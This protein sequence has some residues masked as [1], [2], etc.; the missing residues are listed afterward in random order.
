MSGILSSLTRWL[1]Q[2]QT[3]S[4]KT[5]QRLDE[6]HLFLLSEEWGKIFLEVVALCLIGHS[7]ITRPWKKWGWKAVKVNDTVCHIED[8]KEVLEAAL[9]RLINQEIFTVQH[10]V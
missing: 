9:K 3:A 4:C 5:V 7:Y 2:L 6:R 10:L 8:G 1:Q